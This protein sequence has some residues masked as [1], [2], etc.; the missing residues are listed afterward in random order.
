MIVEEKKADKALAL[1][2]KEVARYEALPTHSPLF[3]H[4]IDDKNL[5]Q[6]GL[7]IIE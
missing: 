1:L 4:L 3:N 2:K 6:M 7:S 5:N